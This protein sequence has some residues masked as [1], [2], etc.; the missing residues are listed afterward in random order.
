MSN[1]VYKQI[2]ITK[3][4]NSVIDFE[5]GSVSFDSG[6]AWFKAIAVFWDNG[7]R[8]HPTYI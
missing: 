1:V 5:H 7:G 6:F 8:L 2:S 3:E 4:N